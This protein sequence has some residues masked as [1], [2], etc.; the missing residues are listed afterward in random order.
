METLDSFC[1]SAPSG[2][3]APRINVPARKA[4]NLRPR[5]E[6]IT[7]RVGMLAAKST[8]YNLAANW[9][10]PALEAD[11]DGAFTVSLA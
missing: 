7:H 8:L 5:N 9:A 11:R 3:N 6:P 1:S 2:L 10:N 4:K